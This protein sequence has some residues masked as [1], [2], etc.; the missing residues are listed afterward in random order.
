MV[1][2]QAS[3]RRRHLRG[4]GRRRRLLRCRLGRISRLRIYRL[5]WISRLR[6]LCGL[7]ASAGLDSSAGL[8]DSDVTAGGE[9]G[10]AGLSSSARAMETL[11]AITTVTASR[12]CQVMEHH[13][14]AVL[15]NLVS[16]PEVRTGLRLARMR[17]SGSRDTSKFMILVPLLDLKFFIG[18][19]ASP[20]ELQIP[21]TRNWRRMCR[22][23][24]AV[25]VLTRAAPKNT[26]NS[27][28]CSIVLTNW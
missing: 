7:A 12:T 16:D 18:L 3:P 19:A 5:R 24:A 8:D 10:G 13:R 20:E 9:T 25:R 26:R 14:V 17:T 4:G 23:K 28:A 11:V 22:H 21:G 15:Y 6:R 2:T 27:E 1:W